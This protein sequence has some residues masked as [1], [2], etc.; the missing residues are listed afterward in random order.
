MPK[1]ASKA[2][3]KAKASKDESKSSKK[4]VEKTEEK[5]SPKADK[6]VEKSPKP[7]PEAV[8]AQTAKTAEVKAEA[9]QTEAAKATPMPNQPFV[10]GTP[11]SQELES[12]QTI[13][14]RAQQAAQAKANQNL[15]G[16]KLKTSDKQAR[17]DAIKGDMFNAA[18]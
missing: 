15:S 6:P 13:N 9:A 5:A 4:Q 7:T 14:H 3:A 16:V 10:N 17:I 12:E 18:G 11:P 8:E 1:K 2:K